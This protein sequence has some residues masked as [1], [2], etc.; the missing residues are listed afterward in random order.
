MHS[1]TNEAFVKSF[2]EKYI[3]NFLPS[4]MAMEIV[5]FGSLSLMYRNLSDFKVKS[6]I[7]G[8][9]GLKSEIF[10]SWLHILVYI[11]NICAHHGKLWTR[12]FSIISP[13]IKTAP[14]FP[15]ISNGLARNNV[16]FNI[17]IV[18]YLINC[19]NPQNTLTKR[20]NDNFQKY[21]NIQV[22]N[23][24]FPDNWEKEDIWK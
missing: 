10:E 7:A 21:P 9:Y 22:S 6:D 11:R 4:W 17:A 1:E 16:Y 2:D 3:N 8:K 15:W 12:K 13:K 23:L 14:Q 19:V 20:L 5:T 18:K 24:G